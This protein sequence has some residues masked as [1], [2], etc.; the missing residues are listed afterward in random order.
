MASST[1][2]GKL[3]GLSR[4]EEL[5]LPHPDWSFVAVNESKD[6]SLE[7]PSR[8]RIISP[9]EL[10][11]SKSRTWTVR[12]CLVGGSPDMEY[13]LKRAV[14]IPADQVTN[15][16]MEFHDYYN[17]LNLTIVFVVYPYFLASKSGIIEIHHKEQIIE[18][19]D[20]EQW[21]LTEEGA[22]PEVWRHEGATVSVSKHLF[23]RRA[24]QKNVVL[25]KT[26]VSK[27]SKCVSMIPDENVLLEWTFTPEEELFF[28]DMRSVMPRDLPSPKMTDRTPGLIGWGASPGVVTGR[29]RIV[30]DS[31]EI[32]DLMPGEILVLQTLTKDVS[33][34]ISRLPRNTGVI[35]ETGGV[36]SHPAIVSREFGIPMIVG[37][38]DASRILKDQQLITMDGS[39][40]MIYFDR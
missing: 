28:Y 6:E 40:G 3:R 9:E 18:A 23:A 20:G 5:V 7:Y 17:G 29:V 25:T 33:K 19:V 10:A 39:T 27:L 21:R 32:I 31:V 14:G 11:L 30:P 12:T 8:L 38:K 16:L 2:F 13:G 15:R 24:G 22:P 35:A 26:Q 37:M 34:L 4:I 36:T 1:R